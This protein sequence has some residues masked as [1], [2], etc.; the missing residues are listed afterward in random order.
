MFILREHFN[1]FRI[2]LLLNMIRSS[3]RLFMI[4]CLFLM[5][6]II[7]NSEMIFKVRWAYS[8]HHSPFLHIFQS[9]HTIFTAITSTPV[10]TCDTILIAFAVLLKAA[11]FFAMTTF[12]M[13]TRGLLYLWLESMRVSIHDGIHGILAILIAFLVAA[14]GAVALGTTA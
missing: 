6:H 11:R 1:I 3:S 7:I 9:I 8:S 14:V 13:L 12:A 2:L 5:F 10:C 4:F